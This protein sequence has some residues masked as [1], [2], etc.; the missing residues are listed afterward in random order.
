MGEH[1][2]A[3]TLRYYAKAYLDDNYS[4]KVLRRYFSAA[5]ITY[6]SCKNLFKKK[7]YHSLVLHH[8]IY[9]PQGIISDTAIKFGISTSTW[10][11]AYRKQCLIFSHNG[12]YHKT[13][14]SETKDTWF[15]FDFTKKK[16]KKIEN[17]LSNRWSGSKDQI[18][19]SKNFIKVKKT[20][21]FKNKINKNLPAVLLLTNVLWDAQLHY[22]NNAFQSMM[23]WIFYTIDYFIGK[24]NL[25]L[26]IRIHPA[27]LTGTLPSR[28]KVNDEIKKKYE[29]L[30]ENIIIIGPDEPENTYELA[31][32]CDC[33]IIYGTKTGV[34]LTSMGII[35]IVAGEA[36]IR[37]KELT[38]DVNSIEEYL[39]TLQKIPFNHRMSEKKIFLALKYAY[40]FFF[41]RMIFVK[42]IKHVNKHNVFEY[43]IRDVNQLNPGID[44]GLDVIC[45]SIILKKNFV[46][47]IDI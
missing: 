18:S 3:G 25:Q 23:D 9:V 4:E 2:L 17:Y 32:L 27:E 43:R 20:K 19:F 7:K 33:A 31:K 14:L 1:A 37:G 30:P 39:K 22:P 13:L 34:E 29:F 46:Y 38:I 6:Y 45:N 24:K 12:T 35:T 8:G 36:W 15:N 41:R 11:T 16:K 44:K 5:L 28:Q 21:S 10:H 40:Y 47:D 26:I 42:S